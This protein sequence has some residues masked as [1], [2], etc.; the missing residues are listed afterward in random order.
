MADTT[1]KDKLIN[2]I[3]QSDDQALLED[4]SALFE[5]QEPETIYRVNA[6]Q[7]KAIEEAKEQIRNNDTLGDDESNSEADQWLKE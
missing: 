1:L 4:A 3:M 2:K 7:R 5:L 6:E